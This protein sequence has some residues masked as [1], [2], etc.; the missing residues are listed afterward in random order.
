MRTEIN[1]EDYITDERIT[2]IIEE[3]LRNIIQRKWN[4]ELSTLLSNVSY[5]NVFSKV[6]EL[7]E[8]DKN[9]EDI[10]VEKTKNIIQDLKSYS[11]FRSKDEYITKEDSVG[12]KILN[13]AVK[14][15]KSLIEKRVVEIINNYDFR[16]LKDDIDSTIY[17]C[18]MRKF[19]E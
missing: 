7:L 3:E 8:D 13:E 6:D 4:N 16:E 5:R 18:I 14:D 9:A 1:I 19:K 2:E 12:Q 11:V 10:I 17:E 15:N